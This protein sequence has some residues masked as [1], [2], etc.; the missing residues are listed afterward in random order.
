MKIAFALTIVTSIVSFVPVFRSH[1]S[2]KSGGCISAIALTR[3][4]PNKE[5][6]LKQMPS[7]DV[8]DWM[9]RFS[10]RIVIRAQFSSS[11]AWFGQHSGGAGNFGGATRLDRS[12]MRQSPLGVHGG[13]KQLSCN[14]GT[15]T[16]CKSQPLVTF[17]RRQFFKPH[18]IFEHF[19]LPFTQTHE[20][21]F[22]SS[23]L[24]SSG[25]SAAIA[26]YGDN[27]VVFRHTDD[28]S[29]KTKTNDLNTIYSE[30]SNLEIK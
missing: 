25:F 17:D 9:A 10:N 19:G 24:K 30:W 4:V 13:D 7:T 22:V 12:N 8:P 27:D 3:R 11:T 23:S 5:R 21:Q 1:N 16:S 28:G 26:L 15:Q 14:V 2:T 18:H 29:D 20:L 6:K